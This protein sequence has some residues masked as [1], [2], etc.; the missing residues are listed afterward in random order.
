MLRVD[1]SHNDLDGLSLDTCGWETWEDCAVN[2]T[3]K[4]T[5]STFSFNGI[6]ENSMS[7]YIYTRNP[8][9]INGFSAIG[10]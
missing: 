6:S 1:V 3:I 5:D 2:G 7:L 10:N 8:I 4:I 9:I